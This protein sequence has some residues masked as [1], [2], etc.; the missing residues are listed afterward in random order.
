MGPV[1]VLSQRATRI[2]FMRRLGR[3]RSLALHGDT[4]LSGTMT[5]ISRK[6]LA[7]VL[8]LAI[9]AGFLAAFW[10]QMSPLWRGVSAGALVLLGALWAG[11]SR[12]QTPVPTTDPRIDILEQVVSDEARRP[13][14]PYTLPWLPSGSSPKPVLL[15]PAADY[16]LAEIVPLAAELNRRDIPTRVAIGDSPWGRTW[17]ALAWHPELEVFA[18]PGADEVAGDVSAVL[19]MK[20]TGSLAPLV[21]RWRE[22]G[23]PVIGKVEGAQDFW[24]ADT[25]EE[26]LPYRNLDLVLCQG[27][28][29]AEALGDRE[30]E[31]VGSTR[32]ERLWWAPPVI[33]TEPL[34]V[35][36]LNFV[37]GV[38]TSDRKLWL[39]TAI[40][41]CEAAGVPYVISL[42]PAEKARLDSDRVTSISASRLLPRATVLISRFSTMPFEAM[43]R[44]V[45]FIYHN[46]HGET[47]RTFADPMGAFKISRSA[48]ELAHAS[49]PLTLWPIPASGLRDSS[50]IT[51][52]STRRA[53]ASDERPRHF[54]PS[55]GIKDEKWAKPSPTAGGGWPC[56]WIGVGWALIAVGIAGDSLAGRGPRRHSGRRREPGLGQDPLRAAIEHVDAGPH[57]TAGVALDLHD[58]R[59]ASSAS[60]PRMMPCERRTAPEEARAAPL[61]AAPMEEKL[62]ERVR[63]AE[64]STNRHRDAVRCPGRRAPPVPRRLRRT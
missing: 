1:G 5:S 44:G 51:R 29:D 24:D 7:A 38:R 20:D 27:K 19:V 8:L 32:L 6:E 2:G 22:L 64:V 31:I 52:P 16:H 42:H 60:A 36:N 43:A 46:P 58:L 41:G 50:P 12:T 57:L 63:R 14:N 33:A 4:V 25:P 23:V 56:W 62:V 37:Y 15:V 26:R 18:L 3:D 59:R 34:A 35:I 11:R 21:T 39:D 28:F 55:W 9:T 17:P 47:V 53:P 54:S 45:P 40:A 13:W 49:T 61:R 30:T 48:D 10:D